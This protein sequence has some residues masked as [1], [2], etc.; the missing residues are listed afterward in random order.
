[1]YGTLCTPKNE[2]RMLLSSD[3][4]FLK[5]QFLENKQNISN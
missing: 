2:H 1:M 5:I 3:D 4:L